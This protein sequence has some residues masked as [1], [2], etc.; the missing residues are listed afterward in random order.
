MEIFAYIDAGSGSMI[1]QVLLAGALAVPFFFRRTIGGAWRRL[2]G[3][4]AETR[5]PRSMTERS[6]H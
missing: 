2:R 5:R 1:L 3:G 6:D 4:D